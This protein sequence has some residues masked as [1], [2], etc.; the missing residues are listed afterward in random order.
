MRNE[1]R[2]AVCG[3][4]DKEGTKMRGTGKEKR[5]KEKENGNTSTTKRTLWK[6][7]RK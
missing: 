3:N 2:A 6:G 7:R 4:D 1:T 5:E